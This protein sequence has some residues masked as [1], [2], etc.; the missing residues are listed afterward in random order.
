MI[1]R[2]RSRRVVNARYMLFSAKAKA[3]ASIWFVCSVCGGKVVDGKCTRQ[4][5]AQNA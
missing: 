1:M 4:L 3:K 2:K 5:G